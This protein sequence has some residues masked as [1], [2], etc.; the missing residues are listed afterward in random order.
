M[1]QT[2][3]NEHNCATLSAFP[4]SVD[5][6]Y[7]SIAVELFASTQDLQD[8]PVPEYIA[9]EMS[10]NLCPTGLPPHLLKLKNGGLVMDIRNLL[11]ST[12]VTAKVFVVKAHTTCVEWVASVDTNGNDTDTYALHCIKAHFPYHG[13]NSP[14]CS[15]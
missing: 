3:G 13:V 14:A 5:N 15:L 7:S 4:G 11:H 9:P 12:F 1:I 6:I 10:Y 2:A 8:S